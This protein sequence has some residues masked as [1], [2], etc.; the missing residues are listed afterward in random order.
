MPFRPHVFAQ[1]ED[2]EIR[3]GERKACELADMFR[4]SP[5]DHRAESTVTQEKGCCPFG[6]RSQYQSSSACAAKAE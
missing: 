2:R 4:L 1:C 5:Q 3:R 6:G